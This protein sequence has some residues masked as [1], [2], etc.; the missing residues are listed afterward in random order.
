MLFQSNVAAFFESVNASVNAL[1]TEARKT[2]TAKRL[3]FFYDE[4]LTQLTTQLEALFADPSNMIKVELNI[5]KKIIKSLAQTYRDRPIRNIIGEQKD[6]DIYSKIVEEAS[7]DVK[8]KQVS[9]LAKL[10]KTILV[11]VVFRNG[12]LDIDILTGNILDVVTGDSPQDLKEVL[13]TDYGNTG[14]LEAVEYSH[15][16]D[17]IFQRLVSGLWDSWFFIEWEDSTTHF[18]LCQTFSLYVFDII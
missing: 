6:K 12:K 9:R 5:I 8:M 10:C 1:S 3:S 4:Q 18:T 17:Q 16:T 13:V 15:W 2:E 11:K 7:L 14:K